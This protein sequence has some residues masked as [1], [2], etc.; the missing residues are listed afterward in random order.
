MRQRFEKNQG[1]LLNLTESFRAHP[2]ILKLLNDFVKLNENIL[3]EGILISED[4]RSAV[5]FAD[6]KE[7][8][9]A[10][11]D[12]F[13]EQRIFSSDNA[14]EGRLREAESIANYIHE[15]VKSRN[16][17][18]SRKN[19]PRFGEPLE[20]R[21]VAVLFRTSSSI[22]AFREELQRRGIPSNA[23]ATS[24]FYQSREVQDT[25]NLLRLLMQPDDDLLLAGILKSE[26]VNLSDAALYELRQ[27]PVDDS[28]WSTIALSAAD[29]EKL[30]K[31]HG[32]FA[33][34]LENPDLFHVYSLL[35]KMVL[36]SD[37]EANL[38]QR[39]SG[40]QLQQKLAN[41]HKLLVQAQIWQSRPP[42]GLSD[43]LKMIEAFENADVKEPQA[44]VV[45]DES[46]VQLLTV[47][48][49][50]GLEFPVVII[51]DLRR[52]MIHNL[53]SLLCDRQG[54]VGFKFRLNDQS[55]AEPELYH[56]IVKSLRDSE[57][58]EEMR[59]LYVAMSRAEQ[60]LVLSS[61][62]GTSLKSSWLKTLSRQFEFK[63]S[64]VKTL[65]DEI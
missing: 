8:P 63:T 53:N 23:S 26:Y 3:S 61:S 12:A 19:H 21:D 39:W 58:A 6:A 27:G 33:P 62:M 22:P 31:F 24:G 54:K 59:I 56:A 13:I 16:V 7:N 28:L 9:N 34:I 52:S 44:D 38:R 55:V 57:S 43:F 49:A 18:I 50:K 42:A 36:A 5:D 25:L 1:V 41:L 40:W 51:A 65:P 60:K 64:F 30:Q 37:Y 4:L 48:A 2:K 10:S 47:H 29:D 14:A 15:L 11:N 35:E 20:Y 32:W 46:A 17:L 45:T